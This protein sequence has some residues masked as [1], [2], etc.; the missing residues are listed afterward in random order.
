[1]LVTKAVS[2]TN[3]ISAAARLLPLR[4]KTELLALPAD[5]ISQI[6]EV[7]LRA[8]QTMKLNFSGTEEEAAP[9]YIIDRDDLESVLECATE[10]SYHA[11]ENELIKG[12]ISVMGGIRLG[13]CG[14]AVMKNGAVGGIRSISSLSIRIP[15]QIKNICADIISE[16]AESKPENLLIIAP[17]GAGKTS[18]LREFVRTAS[19]AGVRVS[20]AD[21]KGEIAAVYDGIA[22]FD[23]G[24]H[25]DILTDAPKAKAVMMLLKSMTP[26]LIALDE[27]SSKEDAE[28]V[29]EAFGCG[30]AIAAT[31]HAKCIDDLYRRR[32]Y[33]EILDA[34]IFKNCI[35]I[36]NEGGRRDYRL[37]KLCT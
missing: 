28:A 2:V 34:G 31:A 25:T 6:E 3:T 32:V 13:V 27:I 22:Q 5:R 30:V 7:R 35:I 8:G 33:A 24:A 4:L 1:M 16:I 18:C 21:E 12:Y 10:A 20:L 19:D 11:V 9:D 36:T 14:N 17:P 15:R 26:E 23:V 29:F 37:E